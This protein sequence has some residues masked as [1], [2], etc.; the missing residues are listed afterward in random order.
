VVRL[1]LP[2]LQVQVE[3]PVAADYPEHPE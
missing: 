3:Q 2:A 1:D